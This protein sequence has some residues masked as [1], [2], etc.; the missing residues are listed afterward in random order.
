MALLLHVGLFAQ[1][2]QVSTA[3]GQETLIVEDAPDIEI[4]AFGKNVIV[5]QH[6]KGVFAFGGNVIVEGIV[7]ADVAT[8]GGSVT[9]KE[10]A[11]IGGDVI[12]LGGTFTAEGKQPLRNAERETVVIGVFEE[13]F[14]NF[15]Q[16]PTAILSPSLSWSFV[17]QRILSVLFWFVITF[18]VTTISPGGI[19]RAVARFQ[20]SS[21]KIIGLGIAGLILSSV[22][23]VVSVGFLPGYLGGILG[24]MMLFLLFSAY[25]FG[26]VALQVSLGKFLQKQLIPV[27]SHSETMAILVGV[28]AWTAILS[29]PYIWT[30]ALIVLFSASIGLVLTAR[31]GNSWQN[32]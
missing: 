25:V 12:V 18:A 9:Q 28:V 19:G 7:D 27:S 4:L 1:A 30:V 11:R 29:I 14:R 3:D 22:G 10:G 16:N 32:S 2:T 26:R 8:I 17:A 24:L 5:K 21:A 20:L 15:A 31:S 6:A 13:E 23:I